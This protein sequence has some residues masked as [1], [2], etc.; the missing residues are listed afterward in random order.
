MSQNSMAGVAVAVGMEYLFQL[1]VE[2][3]FEALHERMMLAR[4]LQL[5]TPVH[6]DTILHIHI[7]ARSGN[8]SVEFV[9]KVLEMCND[10]LWK[11]SS[12]DGHYCTWLLDMD[13]AID[14]ARILIPVRQHLPNSEDEEAARRLLTM[15]TK[16]GDT[17]LHEA[18]RYNHLEVVKILIEVNPDHPCY[19]PNGD[20]KTPLYLACVATAL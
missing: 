14:I 4:P 11:T 8:A 7:T 2:G 1:A 16:S 13:I 6:K 15:V 3:K 18:V 5:V 9:R 17:A 19:R 20:G 12:E 10:L